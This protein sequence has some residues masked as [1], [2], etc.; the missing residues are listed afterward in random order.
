MFYECPDCLLIYTKEAVEFMH[1]SYKS[2]YCE[3]PV[4]QFEVVYE[5]FD[6]SE[7]VVDL[8]EAKEI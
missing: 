8:E 7:D 3:C 2:C 5:D 1:N 6:F 4:G